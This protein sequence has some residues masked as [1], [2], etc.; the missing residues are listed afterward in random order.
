MMS[1]QAMLFADKKEVESGRYVCYYKNKLTGRK[2][3]Y[4]GNIC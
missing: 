1:I 4:N 2:L 3:Q